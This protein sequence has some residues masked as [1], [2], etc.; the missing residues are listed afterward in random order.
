MRRILLAVGGVMQVLIALLHVTMFRGIAL[1]RL[2]A[3]FK[4]TAQIF[5]AAV[6]TTVLFFA[7]VSFFEVRSLTQ[8]RFG[9]AVLLFVAIFYL[10]RALVPLFLRGP[11]LSL[12]LVVCLALALLYGLVAIPSRPQPAQ[13]AAAP[14]EVP[15]S[16][17]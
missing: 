5:N 17:P 7:Y 12:T 2:P 10:Q 3:D 8:R 14:P 13:P 4:V 16:L 6:L 1:S 9:R 11:E 15:A